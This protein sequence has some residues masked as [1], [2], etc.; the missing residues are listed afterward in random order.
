[1]FPLPR[2]IKKKL[3]WPSI[4]SSFVAAVCTLKVEDHPKHTCTVVKA[5]E[6]YLGTTWIFTQEHNIFLH[7]R[8]IGWD[9]G[10]PAHKSM[11]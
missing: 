2:T 10:L 4:Q 9:A 7:L 5:I 11:T 1:M 3:G 6:N 8:L